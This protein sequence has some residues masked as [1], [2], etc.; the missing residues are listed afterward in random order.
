MRLETPTATITDLIWPAQ[1]AARAMLNGGR[2]FLLL[3]AAILAFGLLP[4]AG[5]GRIAGIDI[6]FV[7]IAGLVGGLLL[8]AYGSPRAKTRRLRVDRDT[9]VLERSHH[10]GTGAWAADLT[11]SLADITGLSILECGS[12]DQVSSFS[13]QVTTQ[14]GETT[15]LWP[16]PLATREAADEALETLQRAMAGSA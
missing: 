11:L 10:A 15:S 9:R 16:V 4:G 14:N 2:V 8:W 3:N 13:I 7:A 1:P 5:L 12:D 6:A